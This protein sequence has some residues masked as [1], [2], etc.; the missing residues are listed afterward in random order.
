MTALDAG[1]LTFA[2]GAGFA[3]FLSPCALPLVPGYVGF[4]ARSADG[5]AS[6]A[7]VL[8]RGLAAAGG[9]LLT[10]GLLAALAVILGRPVARLLPLVEPAVGLALVGLG[11]LVVSGRAPALTVQLP[12]RRADTPGFALFG[13]GYAGASAGCVLPVFLAVVVQ[14]L[15]LPLPQAAAVVLVYALGAALPLLALSLL[16]GLGVDVAA[17]RLGGLGSLLERAAGVVL[18]LA[19]MVQ[20]VVAVAPSAVPSTPIPV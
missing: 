4:Y 1:H 13:A 11:V 8:S 2:A 19:G 15:A 18:V 5:D 16:V 10:L 9:L 6:T 12:E 20:L 17:A 3:T 7:G 14:S